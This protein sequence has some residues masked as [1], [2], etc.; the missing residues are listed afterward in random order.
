MPIVAVIPVIVVAAVLFPIIAVDPVVAVV[1]V[2]FPGIVNAKAAATQICTN[3][4]IEALLFWADPP[5]KTFLFMHK[6]YLLSHGP[7]T[8]PWCI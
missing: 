1:V 6:G 8:A 4:I 3:Y 2:L 5:P 7:H